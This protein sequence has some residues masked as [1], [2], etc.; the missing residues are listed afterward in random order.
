MLKE[1]L[2]FISFRPDFFDKDK[3]GFDI[4]KQ[5]TSLAKT[6]DLKFNVYYQD[7]ANVKKIIGSLASEFMIFEE[8][9]EE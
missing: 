6:N 1:F 9:K 8:L 2:I 4:V 3:P 7:F 5:F